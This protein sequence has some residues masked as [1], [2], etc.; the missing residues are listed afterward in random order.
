MHEKAGEALVERF[1]KEI[2]ALK[3]SSDCEND[4]ICLVKIGVQGR[5]NNDQKTTNPE[6]K[7]IIPFYK[8]VMVSAETPIRSLIELCSED[9][10]IEWFLF[11]N[12]LF[13]F[14]PH[15][16]YA[17]MK[18]I[19]EQPAKAYIAGES[20]WENGREVGCYYAQ[21]ILYASDDPRQQGSSNLL[22]H[23]QLLLQC[24]EYDACFFENRFPI[25]A[26]RE[27][28]KACGAELCCVK[29]LLFKADQAFCI[30]PAFFPQPKR[31]KRIFA[32]SHEFSLTGAPVV[33]REALRVIQKNGYVIHTVSAAD[34]P[35]LDQL[36]QDGISVSVDQA[37][38]GRGEEYWTWVVA[39][40]D[41][42]FISTVVGYWLAE[43]MGKYG[44]P[45]FWWI[46]DAN[47]GYPWLSQ[48]MAQKIPKHVHIYCGGDYA[49]KV[50]Q[51]YRP[52]YPAENLLYG[53]QDR[54]GRQGGSFPL[55]K[56][57]K[58][59]FSII[60]SIEERK[61]QSILLKAIEKLPPQI[62]AHCLFLIVGRPL[63]KEHLLLVQEAA[64]KYP[65]NVCYIPS[66][67]RDQIDSVYCQTDCIVC[68]SEDDP[69]PV[70]VA[71]GWMCGTPCI[72]SE[73]TGTA[74]LITEGI[75][76]F[77][78]QDN[79]PEKL[80]EKIALFC[81]LSAAKRAEL[82]TNARSLFT[83]EFDWRKF[84]EK[85]LAITAEIVNGG[86]GS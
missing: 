57:D 64:E 54:Y 74:P 7:Q 25:L 84:E 52:L 43:R 83:R 79:N 34:G 17:F 14:C 77:V 3:P 62:F 36:V 70:F 38:E 61:G 26:L 11:Q 4:H 73:N 18:A 55:E 30:P 19:R 67:P 31:E 75:D 63:D 32:F 78:Y 58:L 24:L 40:Y 59:L 80:A 16:Q 27:R 45:V 60:G 33:F 39:H 9:E 49:R 8:E 6:R 56:K 2:F 66:V 21:N 12:M 53:V 81:G 48:F 10:K 71:E 1:Y 22:I 44:M 41:A 37:L 23:R 85:L 68:A 72:C 47:G 13:S 5:R 86:W 20:Y 50:L 65:E 46:H 82:Q 28:I 42:V 15:T 35:I 69:M 51:K 76:S 29:E